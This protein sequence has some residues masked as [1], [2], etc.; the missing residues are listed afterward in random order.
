MTFLLSSLLCLLLHLSE[1]RISSSTA[2]PVTPSASVPL[3]IRQYKF[4]SHTKQWQYSILLFIYS[5]VRP[6]DKYSGPNVLLF[7][8]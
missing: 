4:H 6:E 3:S 5:D 2:H 7:S 8:S 1:A